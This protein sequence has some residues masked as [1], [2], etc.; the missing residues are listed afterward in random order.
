[1][2]GGGGRKRENRLFSPNN[3][4]FIRLQDCD[5]YLPIGTRIS[6]AM[7]VAVVL[8][9]LGIEIRKMTGVDG[10]QVARAG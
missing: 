9:G 4:Q 6:F 5:A 8:E 1:M 2:S 3:N 10:S 7:E